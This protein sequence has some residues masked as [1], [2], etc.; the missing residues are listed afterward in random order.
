MV[1]DYSQFHATNIDWECQYIIKE[2]FQKMGKLLHCKNIAVHPCQKTSARRVL[3]Y[4]HSI[5]RK[6]LK[7]SI[8]GMLKPQVGHP[9]YINYLFQTSKRWKSCGLERLFNGR[10]LMEYCHKLMGQCINLTDYYHLL[11]NS[12]WFQSDSCYNWLNYYLNCWII[13]ETTPNPSHKKLLSSCK[14]ILMLCLARI[15]WRL[16]QLRFSSKI[17]LT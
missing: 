17:D 2:Q 16:L 12:N 10:N 13:V 7:Q 11:F 3:L 15:N 14:S 5:N 4:F 9:N 1:N 6:I 8:Y